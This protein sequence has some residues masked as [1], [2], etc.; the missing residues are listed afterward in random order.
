MPWIY[1]NCC[2]NLQWMYQQTLCAF[3]WQMREAFDMLL[4]LTIGH[5]FGYSTNMLEKPSEEALQFT[6]SF[7]YALLTASSRSRMGW[8][9]FLVPDRRLDSSVKT[10][11]RFIDHYVAEARSEDRKQERPYMFMTEMLAS[12]ASPEMVRNQLLAMILGGRDT[13]ASTMS[14]LFWV[15]ARRPDV[16]DEMRRDISRLEG[17]KPTWEELK[18]LKYANMV[19]KESEFPRYLFSMRVCC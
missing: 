18:E 16:V 1:S 9:A 10:C 13:S 14:S 8:I 12:G 11:Q 5:R 15:L 2:S 7:D 3:S 4:T 6:T 17:R 19:L